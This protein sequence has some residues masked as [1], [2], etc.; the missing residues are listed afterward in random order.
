L[1]KVN[2]PVILCVLDGWGLSKKIEGNAP[3]IA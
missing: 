1:A 2:K 3:L